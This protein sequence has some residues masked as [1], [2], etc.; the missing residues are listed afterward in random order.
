VLTRKEQA[1]AKARQPNPRS[2]QPH[3]PVAIHTPP[4]A[5]AVSVLEDD[6]A[7]QEVAVALD[8]AERR[9]MNRINQIKQEAQS[10][11]NFLKYLK[12]QL[13]F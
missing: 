2:V 1:D 13:L 6:T 5:N 11:D 10:G 4:P 7:Q 8:G 12:C 9:M 3:L